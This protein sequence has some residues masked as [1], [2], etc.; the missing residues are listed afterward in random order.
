MDRRKVGER[1]MD[2]IVEVS[3]ARRES[4]EDAEVALLR[5]RYAR[6]RGTMSREDAIAAYRDIAKPAGASKPAEW[7]GVL[8]R[9]RVDSYFDPFGNLRIDQRAR[10][11][12]ACELGS[13]K[14]DAVETIRAALTKELTPR[15]ARQLDAYWARD[16]IKPE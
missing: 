12:L 10:V 9:Q 14:A 16:I 15:Q 4:Q 3:G 5:T 13:G 6:L 2:A 11:E 8:D 7:D 1:I